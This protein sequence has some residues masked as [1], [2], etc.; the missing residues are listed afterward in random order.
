MR[1]LT[2]AASATAL[3]VLPIL[4]ACG[5]AVP[6]ASD[7]DAAADLPVAT[8][9]PAPE[10]REFW[11]ALEA[12]CGR[13]YP[14]SISDV[15]PY[16]RDG[17][18][19]RRIVAHFLE[20]S[21]DR[22]HIAFHLDDDRSRNWILTQVGGTLRLKHDHRLEDGTEDEISQ[23]GGD[24]PTPGLPTRQIFPADEHTARILPDR[25]D[26]FWFFDFVEPERLQYG[27]HWPKHGH[28]IRLEFDLSSPVEPP[29]RPWGY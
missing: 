15:T 21:D 10:Q 19:G 17:V 27:V 13:A 1:R 8:S 23:Y 26:N 4:F 29:P 28:S 5:E 11:A 2:K 24:A 14:G 16:Y 25:A 12:H 6:P 22:M 7:L 20:C 18:E 9:Q 3:P